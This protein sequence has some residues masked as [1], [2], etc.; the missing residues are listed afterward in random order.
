M[1]ANVS[2]LRYRDPSTNSIEVDPAQ[3]LESGASSG[4]IASS[5]IASSTRPPDIMEISSPPDEIDNSHIRKDLHFTVTMGESQFTEIMHPKS[6]EDLE[7]YL[8]WRYLV[9]DIF[10]PKP[11]IVENTHEEWKRINLS[12]GEDFKP[13]SQQRYW[14]NQIFLRCAVKQGLYQGYHERDLKLWLEDLHKIACSGLDGNN[15]YYVCKSLREIIKSE[16]VM[17]RYQDQDPEIERSRIEGYLEKFKQFLDLRSSSKNNTQDWLS[18]LAEKYINITL[19]PPFENVNNSIVMNILNLMLKK[20]GMN[21][22]SHSNLDLSF[23]RY[24]SDEDKF[25]KAVGEF[26]HSIFL[27]AILQTNPRLEQELGPLLNTPAEFVDEYQRYLGKL[28]EFH[29][30]GVLSS[31]TYHLMKYL[32][33]RDLHDKCQFL[34]VITD[35]KDLLKKGIEKGVF[36]DELFANF[37]E[38]IPKAFHNLNLS[39]FQEQH[40]LLLVTLG[41]KLRHPDFDTR[42]SSIEDLLS[43]VDRKLTELNIGAFERDVKLRGAGFRFCNTN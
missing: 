17:T 32:S 24:K 4:E 36:T 28:S 5:E 34:E 26:P 22:I 3:G 15:H 35:I 39:G 38:N 18:D 7:K 30:S 23:F 21:E 25:Q 40:F 37:S 14:Q 11:K 12:L 33:V 6:E 2:G 1:G 27:R 13:I 19:C 16:G 29:S 10:Q 8:P 43:R 31:K 42:V 20:H 9:R 41:L